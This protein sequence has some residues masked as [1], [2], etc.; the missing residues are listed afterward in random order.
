MKQGHEAIR[1]T[2]KELTK[3]VSGAPYVMERPSVM[4]ERQSP[5]CLEMVCLDRMDQTYI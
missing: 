2:D 1:L 4:K 3:H 5:G